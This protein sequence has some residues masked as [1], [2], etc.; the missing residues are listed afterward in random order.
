[1]NICIHHC[2]VHS[3]ILVSQKGHNRKR[4]SNRNLPYFSHIISLIPWFSVF[5]KCVFCFQ[6]FTKYNSSYQWFLCTF[7]GNFLPVVSYKYE[8]TKTPNIQTLNG[9][10]DGYAYFGINFQILDSRT[11]ESHSVTRLIQ[12]HLVHLIPQHFTRVLTEAVRIF[13][14]VCPIYSDFL[15]VS[16][17]DNLILINWRVVCCNI[18]YLW[19]HRHSIWTSLMG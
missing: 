5:P 8:T 15:K 19:E 6:Q 17:S 12:N 14:R 3:N 9:Y 13:P 1:M 10:V 18:C 7:E 2:V 11:S 16:T 4:K